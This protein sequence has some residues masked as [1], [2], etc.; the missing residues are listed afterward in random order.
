MKS[1]AKLVPDS[2]GAIPLRGRSAALRAEPV[3]LSQAK[4]PAAI[5]DSRGTLRPTFVCRQHKTPHPRGHRQ[6]LTARGVSTL[7]RRPRG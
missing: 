4:P 7:S 3:A 1:R 5:A 6:W 2:M